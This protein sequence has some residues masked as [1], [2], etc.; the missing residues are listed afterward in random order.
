MKLFPIAVAAGVLLSISCARAKGDSASSTHVLSREELVAIANG[1]RANLEAFG[2]FTCE[3]T[4]RVGVAASEADAIAGRIATSEEELATG[5]GRDMSGGA[6][7]A[8][9]IWIQDGAKRRFEENVPDSVDLAKKIKS[10]KISSVCARSGRELTDGDV[11]MHFN[12]IMSSGAVFDAA[13]PFEREILY[14]FDYAVPN[15]RSGFLEI[16]QKTLATTRLEVTT[17]ASNGR[18]VQENLRLDWRRRDHSKPEPNTFSTSWTIDPQKGFVAREIIH[19]TADGLAV[20]KAIVT[21][22][23]HIGN[24]GWL[25]MRSVYLAGFGRIG[26]KRSIKSA[27]IAS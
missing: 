16:M 7:R 6:V 17:T 18:Q 15:V 10:H 12:L 14:P 2:Q 5:A 23:E 20:D 4:L 21:D 3:Y 9:C 25:P 22:I 8:H 13:Y 27:R 1:Y 11:G 24:S 26:Q 19:S